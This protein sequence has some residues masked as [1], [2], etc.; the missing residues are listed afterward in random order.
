[1]SKDN[2]PQEQVVVKPVEK[3]SDED[4]H[5][6]DMEKMKRELALTKATMADTAYN[7]LV[8]Q[9]AMKYHLT[10]GDT[11]SDAGEITRKVK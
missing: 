3:L 4:R 7:N 5:V 11:I 8:L 6:L 10:E 2:K 9:L 1:M